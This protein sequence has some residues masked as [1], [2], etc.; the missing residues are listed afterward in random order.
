MMA[1]MTVLTITE[2]ARRKVLELRA[3]EPEADRLALC[4]EV[5]GTRGGEYTYDLYFQPIEEAEPTDVVQDDGEL[6]VVIPADSVDALRGATLD[7]SRDLLNPGMVMVNPNRPPTPASPQ[8]GEAPLEL[9][10]TVEE[11]VRQVLEARIN[12]AIAA[13]GGRAE[14]D[15]VEGDTVFL[16]LAGGCQGCAMSR[17]TLT[18]GI[19]V[20][21]REAIP[22]IGRVVDV[23]DHAAG[24]DPFYR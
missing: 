11:R 9:T 23:T 13:H 15:R 6:K 1:A 14:L 5:T 20:T 21:L 4:V 19:E 22:E 7:M 10:G 3:A 2:P 16:R 18:Q 17:M 8:M 12:P 24:A